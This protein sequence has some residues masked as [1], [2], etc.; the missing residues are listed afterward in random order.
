MARAPV[1]RV[2]DITQQTADYPFLLQLEQR[3]DEELVVRLP[4]S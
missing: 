4:G 2:G 1:A 3:I